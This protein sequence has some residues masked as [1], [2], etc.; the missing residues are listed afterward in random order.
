MSK[1]RITPIQREIVKLIDDGF[2]T[3]GIARELHRG[4][5]GVKD[6]IRKLCREFNCPMREL[7]AKTGITRGEG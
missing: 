7:P 1:P 6:H 5:W 4:K 3:E 2:D